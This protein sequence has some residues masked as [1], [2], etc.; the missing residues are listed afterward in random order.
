MVK[1]TLWKHMV[2][3]SSFWKFAL[4][5]ELYVCDVNKHRLSI[6]GHTA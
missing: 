1:L 3:L 6:Y 2:S 4:V 5:S